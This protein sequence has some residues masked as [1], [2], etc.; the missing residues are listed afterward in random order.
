M[1]AKDFKG[2][3]FAGAPPDTTHDWILHVWREGHV[4]GLGKKYK[5][6]SRP[7]HMQSP[8]TDSKAIPFEVESP[9]GEV[10]A[11]G[12]VK[13]SLKVT[14]ATR[15]TQNLL[16]VWT[17]ELTT[18]AEGGRVVSTAARERSLCRLRLRIGCPR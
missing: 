7:V 16:V 9:V 1:K 10:S 3:M 17:A 2:K 6:E 4:E 14:R 18:G 11:K 13:F 12:P 5:F 15:A 8:E